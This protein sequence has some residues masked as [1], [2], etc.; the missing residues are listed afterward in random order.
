M[1]KTFSKSYILSPLELT[2]DYIVLNSCMLDTTCFTYAEGNFIKVP[3]LRDR[4]L[5]AQNISAQVIQCHKK[6]VSLSSVRRRLCEA[7]LSGRIAF[8]KPLLRKQN[9]VK[10]LQ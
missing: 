2:L 4:R 7:G 10:R 9:N 3:S 6:N 5:I 8:K 1:N